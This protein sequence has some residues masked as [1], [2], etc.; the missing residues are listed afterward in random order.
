M[1]KE[2]RKKLYGTIRH[3]FFRAMCGICLICSVGFFIAYILGGI[4]LKLFLGC[5]FIATGMA[6]AM[7]DPDA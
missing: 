7:I 5:S 2:K 1:D 3:L 6:Y 4:S